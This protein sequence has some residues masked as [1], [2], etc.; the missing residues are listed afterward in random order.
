MVPKTLEIWL[1]SPVAQHHAVCSLATMDS[2]YLAED[3][4]PLKAFMLCLYSFTSFEFLYL[5]F[6]SG[7]FPLILLDSA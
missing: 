5:P 2:L 1:S 6:V 7:Q 4:M 3:T